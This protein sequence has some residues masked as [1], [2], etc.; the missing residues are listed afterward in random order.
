MVGD[1][2]GSISGLDK[3]G[4]IFMGHRRGMMSVGDWKVSMC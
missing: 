2:R 4:M 1:G 3:R